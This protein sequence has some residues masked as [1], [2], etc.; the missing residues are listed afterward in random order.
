MVDFAI[1]VSEGVETDADFF[2]EC[3]VKVGERRGLGVL[4]VAASFELARRAAGDQDRQVDM[5]VDVGVAHAAAIEQEH[6]VEQ[7]AVAFGRGFELLEEISEERDVE[8]VDLSYLRD[9][10]DVAAMVRERVMIGVLTQI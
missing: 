2:E 7:R 3:Q 10:L 5:V 4:N 9:F 8:G 1:A 6:M